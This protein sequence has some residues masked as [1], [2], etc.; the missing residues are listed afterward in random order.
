MWESNHYLM[1]SRKN[2]GSFSHVF[3]IHAAFQSC[4]KQNAQITRLFKSNE[5]V[6]HQHPHHQN[7]HFIFFFNGGG[8]AKLNDE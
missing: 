8:V 5:N 3:N 2:V 1:K 6:S 7:K 4:S